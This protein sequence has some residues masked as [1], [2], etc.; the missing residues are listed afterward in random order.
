MQFTFTH[1]YQ[2]YTIQ[3]PQSV[4]SSELAQIKFSNYLT[5]S[6]TLLAAVIWHLQYSKILE[7]QLYS[8]SCAHIL[9]GITEGH[10]IYFL[11]ETTEQ[12]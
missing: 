2:S 3:V 11:T 12:L 8:E 1:N 5:N 6:D 4:N 7:V 9:E 10:V